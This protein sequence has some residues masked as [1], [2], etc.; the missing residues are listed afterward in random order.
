MKRGFHLRSILAIATTAV[1]LTACGPAPKRTKQE[2]KKPKTELVG[3]T[4]EQLQPDKPTTREETPA[5]KLKSE[6]A[7]YPHSPS[8]TVIMIPKGDV[9]ASITKLKGGG[10]KLIYDPNNGFG[11]DIPFFI[12]TLT[13]EQINNAKFI[14]GLGLKAAAIDGPNSTIKPISASNSDLNTSTFIPV[15]SVKLEALLSGSKEQKDLGKG[16]TV[17]VIDSGIDASHPAFNGRV[18]YWYDGTEETNTKLLK[19]EVTEAGEIELP[20]K[21]KG[22]N[23]KVT[24]PKEAPKGDTYYAILNEKAYQSQ[25][26]EEAQQKFGYKDINSNG[27]AD[28]FLVV[29]I[30][31]EQGKHVYIDSDADLKLEHNSEKVLKKDYNETTQENR[32]EGMVEFPSR[33]NIRRYPILLTEEG[34]DN[35]IGLGI[36][37]GMHGTHVAGIIA[38]NYPEANLLGAA[39][40]ARLMALRV[41]SD[42]S[43]TDSAIIKGLYQ[44]FY[45][46][47][48]I[49]DVVNISLGTLEKSSRDIYSHIFND[50]SAKF[51]TVFFVAASNDGPGFRTINHFGNSGPVVMVG[52]NVSR[53]TLA[54]QY[55]LPESSLNMP[56]EG[57]LNF[58]S[59]GPSYTGELKPNIVAPGAAISS[60][61][62]AE[63][64]IAQA[65]GTSMASPMAA[66]TMAAIL[67]EIKA[68]SSDLFEKIETIRKANSERT[69]KSNGT[70]LPYSY[71]MRDA[72]QM[73]ATELGHLTR[74]QQGYGLINAGKTKTLLSQSLEQLNKDEIDYFEVT[75]NEYGTSYERDGEISKVKHFEL[76]LGKD[77]ER[78]KEDLVQMMARGVQVKLERVEI[79]SADGSV[80]KVK[81]KSKTN[82]FH[83][84]KFGTDDG[85]NTETTVVFNNYRN[86]EFMSARHKASYE[87]GKTYIAHYS[88]NY[89]GKNIS[90]V[91]DVVHMPLEFKKQDISVP[92][93]NLKK[94]STE[95]G[96]AFS[97]REIGPNEYHRYPV[98]VGKNQRSF[99]LKI[100]L[101]ASTT[102]RF[103]VTAYNP[104]GQKVYS[105]IAQN[106][107]M[108]DYENI[109]ARVSTIA[110][111]KVLPGIYEVTIATAS[112]MWLAPAKYDILMENFSFG[113]LSSRFDIAAG[114][115]LE[116]AVG[117]QRM[118]V[119]TAEID[120][121][122]QAHIQEVEVKS[123]HISYHPLVRPK[124]T[125]IIAA[126]FEGEAEHFW[127]RLEPALY[128]KTSAGFVKAPAIQAKSISAGEV[129]FIGVPNDLP[130]YYAV[131]TITN[132]D[133]KPS[134]K[135][136]AEKTNNSVN[137]MLIYAK[138]VDVNTEI[139]GKKLT[140]DFSLI[141]F[142]AEPK[143]K[144]EAMEPNAPVYVLSTLKLSSFSSDSDDQIEQIKAGQAQTQEV[145]IL[146]KY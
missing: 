2:K 139:T 95:A 61:L 62:L 28:K 83:I 8:L 48:Y 50:L 24:L 56:K 22:E 49:P 89:K 130:L 114:K 138:K 12:A 106:T 64:G 57:L 127:G 133:L 29:M 36:P 113:A 98:L 26:T 96:I 1:L 87:A 102:G 92:N 93:I 14:K 104:N 85:Q 99:D 5:E 30:K 79:L 112:S 80:Q 84:I 108:S 115:L 54:E 60:T 7:K 140:D 16:I 145:E 21:S 18:D 109:E 126:K 88:I 46:G 11:G 110:D 117:T 144:L 131:D 47:K 74:A 42:I 37:D 137:I 81:D 70:L 143:H 40:S 107:P 124:D 34:E 122:Y 116:I 58:S 121:S 71:A 20:I 31:N 43:C 45:N 146:V 135:E 118:P 90:N 53:K 82:Y 73:G 75:L 94:T 15:D 51:G 3:K 91:L 19:V 38:A 63:D 132:Y 9:Q 39:P 123:H 13:P 76:A 66:G 25:L 67:G 69:E 59:L 44:S 86:T 141:K 129:V 142:I 52:A 97:N 134:E 111:K 32:I 72:L 120:S 35:Y 100:S 6:L 101:A 4:E 27:Q 103:F 55:N 119:K 41:C 23:I 10:G 68:D 33:T 65:N 78:L 128:L 125:P 17:A 136:D 77:G 105:G